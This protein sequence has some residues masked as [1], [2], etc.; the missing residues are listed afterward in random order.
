[1][2]TGPTVVGILLAVL[3]AAILF[4]V[5]RSVVCWYFRIG[6][7]VALQK[8]QVVILK[9]LLDMAIRQEAIRRACEEGDAVA[10]DDTPR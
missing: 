8:E 9:G 2:V 3:T 5:L 10:T 4:W 6:E 7:R 1:M